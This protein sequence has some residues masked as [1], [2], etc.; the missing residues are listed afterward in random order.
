M[1]CYIKKKVLMLKVI[2]IKKKRKDNEK[3]IRTLLKNKNK[4]DQKFWCQAR[5]SSEGTRSSGLLHA[6][7]LKETLEENRSSGLLH[8][9][10]LSVKT[11]R[12]ILEVLCYVKTVRKL[13]SS[14][15]V[16]TV[17]KPRSSGILK[18]W[19]KNQKFCVLCYNSEKETKK[20]CFVLK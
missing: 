6:E 3:R 8:A 17:R 1:S 19:E 15:C 10:V 16:K 11:V 18:Q 12:K 13:R 7:V 2:R 4:R 14:V 20:L 9:E 5:C